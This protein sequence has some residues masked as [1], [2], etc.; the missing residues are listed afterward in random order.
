MSTGRSWL[1]LSRGRF[2][3]APAID[4]GGGGLD[5]FGPQST[6]RFLIAEMMLGLKDNVY[7]GSASTLGRGGD[8]AA[9]LSRGGGSSASLF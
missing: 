8:S 3:G 1:G 4:T 5:R 9:S 6:L 2:K 7:T